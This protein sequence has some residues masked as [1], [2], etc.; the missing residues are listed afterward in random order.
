M[1]TNTI[2]V[3]RSGCLWPIVCIVLATYIILYKPPYTSLYVTIPPGQTQLEI[4]LELHPQASES[5][6]Y[7]NNDIPNRILVVGQPG[8]HEVKVYLRP[9]TK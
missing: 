9:A 5:E 2:V 6:V 8:K 7:V 4:D 3:R 1:T